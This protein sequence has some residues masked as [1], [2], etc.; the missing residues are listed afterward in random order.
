V[1]PAERL[2]EVFA[3]AEQWRR[4]LA[5]VRR[6]W[7]CWCVD[8]DWCYVQQQ[9]V[10]AAGWTPVVG[11]DG[12]SPRPPL[13]PGAVFLDFNALLRLPLMWMHFP[14]EF[15]HLF[16]DRLAFWHSDV[17]PPVRVMRRLAAQFES[18]EDG[19]LAAVKRERVGM[20]QRAKRLLKRK[21]LF[22][23]RWFEVTGCTTAAASRSQY[24][25]GCGWWRYPQRHPNAQPWIADA[26]SREHGVGIW[27]W[28]RQC[29][30]SALDLAVDV[31]PY[32]YSTN[33][34]G[35]RREWKDSAT[36]AANKQMELKAS[37]ELRD[38]VSGL[39]L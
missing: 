10:S 18:L 4:T 12:G 5:D 24:E 33:K 2:P 16:A 31:E 36:I 28:E 8:E 22:Y 19:Q 1:F 11:T 7:L 37:F 6:P 23:K 30:G 3:A 35:Y 25:Q 34:A 13:V 14:L 39:G 9:L 27:Y 20:V 15:A 21:P 26:Y 17:L 32:H 29:G 38:I